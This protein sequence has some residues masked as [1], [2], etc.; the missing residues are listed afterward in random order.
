MHDEITE[1]REVRWSKM[2]WFPLIIAAIAP[3][4][5]LITYFYLRDYYDAEPIIM[6]AKMFLLGVLIVLPIM[7]IQRGLVLW[8]GDSSTFVNSFIVAALVEEGL[9]WFVLYHI[10]FNHTVFDEPYD[11]IVYAV[12]IS[13]GFATIENLLYAVTQT[14]GLGDLLIRA[15]IPVSGHALFAVTMGYY[16][17]RARFVQLKWIK[18]LLILS[19]CL[20]TLEHGIMDWVMVLQLT[21]WL[22]VIV[23]LMVLLWIRSL[24]KIHHANQHSPFR[25]FDTNE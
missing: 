2:S 3:G 20:P 24:W 23:P 4:I 12:A 18:V 21:Y 10:I 9:K 17:G 5:A 11:G 13:L 8:W 6:V 14:I 19:L 16:M 22:W 25:A 15:L 1:T 7:I